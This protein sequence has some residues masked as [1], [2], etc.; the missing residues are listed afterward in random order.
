MTNRLRPRDPRRLWRWAKR[1]WQWLL[2]DCRD[3][4]EDLRTLTRGHS[5]PPRDVATVRPPDRLLSVRDQA[6]HLYGELRGRR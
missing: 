6:D 3:L 2:R 5:E 1:E 4:R